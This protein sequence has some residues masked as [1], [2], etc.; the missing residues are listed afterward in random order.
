MRA[1]FFNP[2][3]DTKALNFQRMTGFPMGLVSIA[4]YLNRHGHT[5][6]VID[7]TFCGEAL[8]TLLEKYAPDVVGI[9]L[10][11]NLTIPDMILVSDF[12]RARKIPV[13][14]GGTYASMIS[15]IILKEDKADLVT[16]GEGE[17]IWLNI[18]NELNLVVTS[19]CEVD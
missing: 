18:L 2:N 19:S 8:E 15:D 1:L 13:I 7:R 6:S 11:S 10:V 16:V 14:L 9:S 12:F 17:R 4:T 3:Y 5:A